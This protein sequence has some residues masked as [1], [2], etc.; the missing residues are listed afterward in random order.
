MKTCFKLFIVLFIIT[1]MTLYHCNE[2][3]KNVDATISSVSSSNQLQRVMSVINNISSDPTFINLE[4]SKRRTMQNI[5]KSEQSQNNTKSNVL[6]HT[7]SLHNVRNDLIRSDSAKKIKVY[8]RADHNSKR[9]ILNN[10]LSAE[11]LTDDT[12]YTNLNDGDSNRQIYEAK[13]NLKQ[14]YFVENSTKNEIEN[15]NVNSTIIHD[16]FNKQTVLTSSE[17][18]RQEKRAN[19][20]DGNPVVGYV[21][22]DNK[23][24]I[25]SRNDSNNNYDQNIFTKSSKQ[26]Q[27]K[28]ISF[29]DKL[30]FINLNNSMSSIQNRK[31][32]GYT[33]Q[34]YSSFSHREEQILEDENLNELVHKYTPKQFKIDEKR[35]LI[36]NVAN[37]NSLLNEP[38][39]EAFK[40]THNYSLTNITYVRDY[41]IIRYNHEGQEIP[42]AEDSVQSGSIEFTNH[43]SNS[44]DQMSSFQAVPVLNKMN[45]SQ[46]T[47]SSQQSRATHLL[48]SNSVLDEELQFESS[49]LSTNNI[50]PR[51]VIQEN[52][53]ISTVQTQEKMEVT[54][55]PGLLKEVGTEL[56]RA[57]TLN[58]AFERLLQ[59]LHIVGQ[60]DSYLTDKI[61]SVLRRLALFYDDNYGPGNRRRRRHE[62]ENVSPI[63]D[64]DYSYDYNYDYYYD[65]SYRQRHK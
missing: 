17:P 7:A 20:Y 6:Y 37:N 31:I 45:S 13:Q 32:N 1:K 8:S 5:A 11:L 59:F 55:L 39:E 38:K 2:L 65:D 42:Q 35:N 19:Q 25:F 41:P 4:G 43:I 63:P 23:Q 36:S 15:N 3:S 21:L 12:P 22:Q 26:I 28:S 33:N 44:D 47:I 40:P 50:K 18:T 10:Y 52:S 54:T 56:E 27:S 14:N 29:D 49:V 58:R 30:N 46:S 34:S 57:E 9:L 60:V 51:H 62:D 53:K 24:L 61:K 48:N 16:N 64:D